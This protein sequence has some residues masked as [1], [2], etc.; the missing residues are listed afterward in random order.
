MTAL[1]VLL[2]A[3]LMCLSS[4]LLWQ[5]NSFQQVI[6]TAQSS[7]DA[8][9]KLSRHPPHSVALRAGDLPGYTG[10]T[11]PSE[12]CA[13]HYRILSMFP[14]ATVEVNTE[15]KVV[16]ACNGPTVPTVCTLHQAYFYVR[17]YGPSV[18]TG[19]VRKMESRPGSYEIIFVPP[20]EGQYTVEIVLTFS[21]V[22]SFEAFPLR[23][24]VEEPAYE[25]YLLPEFPLQLTVTDRDKD[26]ASR[27]KP[28]C[29]LQDLQVQNAL[30]GHEK[31]RW[32]VIDRVNS[33]TSR[34]RGKGSV[35][36]YSWRAYQD[37]ETSMG[38][39]MKYEFLACSLSP[40]SKILKVFS[41]YRK[42]KRRSI[43]VVFIGDSVMRMQEEFFRFN[44]RGVEG[45]RSTIISTSG[46]ILAT[47]GNVTESLHAIEQENPLEK[48]FILFNI[49]LHEVYTHCNTRIHFRE[50]H[51]ELDSDEPC[52][53]GFRTRMAD[54][55]KLIESV[56]AEL[57]S[58]QITTAGKDTFVRTE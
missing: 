58:F 44:T 8:I 47:R 49:G 22:P 56:P 14:S 21:S 26:R 6:T 53:P 35:A 25:G 38:I 30:E 11:R 51:P 48:R 3:A 55:V 7:N 18:I 50:L 40:L 10:W 23:K 45:V 20:D 17:A 4:I 27:A 52:L 33:A 29:S 28:T 9:M 57:R 13:G 24:G 19:R 43:H 16:V 2:L 54:L 39:H 1:N 32:R 31:A 46:G 36:E 37:L 34:K 12:T 5:H 41:S 15:W 42:K